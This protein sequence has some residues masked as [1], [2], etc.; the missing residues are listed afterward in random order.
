MQPEPPENPCPR[1]KTED[2]QLVD[3]SEVRNMDAY[4]IQ[5][6]LETTTDTFCKSPYIL[7]VPSLV[8][9]IK[10]KQDPPLFI[11]SLTA[12]LYCCPFMEVFQRS[13]TRRLHFSSVL[14]GTLPNVGFSATVFRTQRQFVQR[15]VQEAVN[16]M[17]FAVLRGLSGQNMLVIGRGRVFMLFCHLRTLPSFFLHTC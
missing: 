7:S 8:S 14:F 16:A 3:S 17:Y 2:C 13:S 1:S 6:V 10:L 11:C 4:S 5:P 9:T 15:K 12:P